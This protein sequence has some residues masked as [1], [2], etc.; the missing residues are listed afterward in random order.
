M[1]DTDQLEK[2]EDLLVTRQDRH[3]FLQAEKHLD[4]DF[5]VEIEDQDIHE[6]DVAL[7]EKVEAM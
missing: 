6:L 5:T 3:A 7:E 2:L 4:K 1:W